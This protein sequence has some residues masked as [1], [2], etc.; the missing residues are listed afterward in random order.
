M[1]ILQTHTREEDVCEQAC[2]ALANLMVSNDAAI[3]NPLSYEENAP[4]ILRIVEEIV[5]ES[6]EPVRI[7]V[8]DDW[9]HVARL[10]T[11]QLVPEQQSQESLWWPF[12]RSDHN[13]SQDCPRSESN[14]IKR[15]L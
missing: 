15:C 8:R 6:A 5:K 3:K 4:G 11:Y 12:A 13:M 10:P 1:T 7:E 14:K 2:S 9:P